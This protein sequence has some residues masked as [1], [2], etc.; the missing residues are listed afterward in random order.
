MEAASTEWS[1]LRTAHPSCHPLHLAIDA[2]VLSYATGPNAVLLEQ[3]VSVA[4]KANV[5]GF[6][7]LPSEPQPCALLLPILPFPDA[8]RVLAF[9]LLRRPTV[10]DEPNRHVAAGQ[11]I[12]PGEWSSV[13]VK[14]SRR[15]AHAVLAEFLAVLE[16]T[17]VGSAAQDRYRGIQKRIPQPRAKDLLSHVLTDEQRAW[18]TEMAQRAAPRAAVAVAS[19]GLAELAGLGA[20]VKIAADIVGDLS[21]LTGDVE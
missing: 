14:A 15:R 17:K 12:L 3:W 18:A 2:T 7:G 19:V 9:D 20:L 16:A 13:L 21:R 4:M 11:M 5:E 8:A 10:E 6:Y 1:R